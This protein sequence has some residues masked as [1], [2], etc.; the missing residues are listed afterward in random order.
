VVIEMCVCRDMACEVSCGCIVLM[1]LGWLGC[2]RVIC[3]MGTVPVE[4]VEN[5]YIRCCLR[6]SVSAFADGMV[7]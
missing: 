4:C 7:V 1:G 5:T 6:V 2:V 3:V